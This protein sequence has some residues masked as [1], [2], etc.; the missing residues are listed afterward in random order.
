MTAAP[1]NEPAFTD[2]EAQHTGRWQRKLMWWMVFMPSVLIGVF[3]VLATL[4]LN[5]FNKEIETYQQSELEPIRIAANESRNASW[6]NQAEYVQFYTLAKMEEIAM[7]KRYS[8]GGVLLMSRVLTKYLGFFTGMILA[9]V[10]AVFII[11]KLKEDR[12]EISAS[13]KENVS[14]NIVST[15]PGIIFGF[16]GTV[17]MLATIL[18]HSEINI[19]DMPLYLNSGN[20]S[21]L[22]NLPKGAETPLVDSSAIA[23]LPEDSQQLSRNVHDD[24]IMKHARPE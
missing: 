10:G 3:I 12:S 6:I 5:R 24:S 16:L 17:L 14:A 15:S 7:R 4:Q 2:S 22:V 13:F 11:S 20:L 19:K 8:Q 1:I 9:I 23:N 18:Q 21:N